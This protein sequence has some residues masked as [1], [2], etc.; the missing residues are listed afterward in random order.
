MRLK[1]KKVITVVLDTEHD[2]R[3]SSLDKT[4]WYSQSRTTKVV[5]V[6]NAGKPDERTK[7]A[8]TGGGYMWNL[9]SYWRFAERD[10][11][12]Y[13]ECQAVSLSRGIPWGFGWIIGPIVNDL[14]KD[15]LS[16]TLTATRAGVAKLVATPSR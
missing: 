10:G 6:E 11:G 13:V 16:N 7:P 8:G 2:A 9:N 5:D 12:V 4:R 15:S 14:P 3:F 1:K